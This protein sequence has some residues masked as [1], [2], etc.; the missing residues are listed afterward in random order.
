[1][2][3]N[4]EAERFDAAQSAD[5]QLNSGRPSLEIGS[6]IGLRRRSELVNGVG[7]VDDDGLLDRYK[8]TDHQ[9]CAPIAR[10]E[11]LT[12]RLA[13]ARARARY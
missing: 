11:L 7:Q 1:M 10:L 9:Q 6:E 13:R 2:Q 3:P 8:G 4:D 5:W 12:S